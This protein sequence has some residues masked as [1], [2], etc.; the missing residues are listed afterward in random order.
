[1]SVKSVM[2]SNWFKIVLL[3]LAFSAIVLVSSMLFACGLGFRKRTF[4]LRG[5]YMA[6]AVALVVF[7]VRWL[8]VKYNFAGLW[9]G[10]MN[11]LYSHQEDFVLRIHRDY[12]ELMS[13]YPLAI[14]E[15]ES[16]CWKQDPRPSTPEI[17][18]SALAIKE[19]EW[20]EREKKARKKMEEKRHNK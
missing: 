20:I 7:T 10:M 3:L 2:K 8:C 17:M 18:E 4:L 12:Q 14:A 11:D 15:Y 16:H 6:I 19:T 9:Q 13:K 5:T 1:M